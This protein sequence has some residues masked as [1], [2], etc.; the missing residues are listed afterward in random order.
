MPVIFSSS[1]RMV[2]L[3][4]AQFESGPKKPAHRE[5][6]SRRDKNQSAVSRPLLVTYWAL[7]SII[8]LGMSTAV[9]HSRRHWWQ[10]THRSATDLTSSVVSS[11][12]PSSPLMMPRIRLALAPGEAPPE[13]PEGKMGHTPASG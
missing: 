12:A 4:K 13:G 7:A 6:Q 8:I 5:S 3:C 11:P 1:H 2:R 9:G 10:L